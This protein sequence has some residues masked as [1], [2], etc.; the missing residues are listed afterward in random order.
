MGERL[1]WEIF[2]G[3]E[4]GGWKVLRSREFHGPGARIKGLKPRCILLGE[5]TIV[6]TTTVVRTVGRELVC[7]PWI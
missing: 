4:A 3:D 6:R 1:L 7:L 2:V 5:P